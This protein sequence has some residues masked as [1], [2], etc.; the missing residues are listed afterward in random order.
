MREVDVSHEN[1]LDAGEQAG[2]PA[3]EARLAGMAEALGAHH[4]S[5][6]RQNS[7]RDEDTDG[8]GDLGWLWLRATPRQ[9]PDETHDLMVR[10]SAA[11]DNWLISLPDG[12]TRHIPVGDDVPNPAAIADLLWS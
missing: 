10:Y 12:R 4:L 6:M 3:L 9:F 2:G 11:D 8:T 1:L 5:V 7:Y